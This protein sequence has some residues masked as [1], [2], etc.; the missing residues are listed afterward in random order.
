MS[1]KLLIALLVV[2]FFMYVATSLGFEGDIV[3]LVSPSYYFTDNHCLNFSLSQKVSAHGM[4]K[5]RYV[6]N[7]TIL[8]EWLWWKLSVLYYRQYNNDAHCV[9]FFAHIGNGRS[10]HGLCPCQ[11]S[12]HTS[13]KA[14]IHVP[15]L[16]IISVNE[17]YA[18]TVDGSETEGRKHKVNV[19][20]VCSTSS[21]SCS[22]TADL[23]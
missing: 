8:F 9:C 22:I 17:L 2:G 1:E 21:I 3:R 14:I 7:G 15:V 5:F 11:W 13:V 20:S 4:D 12:N 16:S 23:W 19:L 10:A 18:S 6:M